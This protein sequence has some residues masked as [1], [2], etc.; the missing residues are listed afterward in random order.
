MSGAVPFTDETIPIL[1]SL[2]NL[3]PKTLACMHGSSFAGDCG[4]ALR[5]FGTILERINGKTGH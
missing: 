2:A 1:E 4:E 3:N 5:D